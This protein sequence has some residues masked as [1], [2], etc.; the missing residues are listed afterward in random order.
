[1]PQPRGE[2]SSDEEALN[3]WPSD[4]VFGGG[5]EKPL[6]VPR[7]QGLAEDLVFDEAWM[8]L[9]PSVLRP[10]GVDDPHSGWVVPPREPAPPTFANRYCTRETLNGSW[11]LL[12]RALV[13]APGLTGLLRGPM[14][15]EVTEDSLRVSGDMYYKDPDRSFEWSRERIFDGPLPPVDSLHPPSRA[16]FVP[17]WGH[18]WYPHYPFNQY[19]WYFRSVGASF[20]GGELY[21]P[22]TRHLWN[23]ASEEDGGQEFD[24]VTDTGWMRFPCSRW[25]GETRGYPQ[26]TVTMQGE[27]MIGGQRF[28]VEAVKTSPYYRG[29]VVEVDIMQNRKLPGTPNGR[30]FSGAFREAGLD[31]RMLVSERDVPEDDSLSHPDA[32]MIRASELQELMEQRREIST[33][34]HSWRLWALVGSYLAEDPN[35]LGMMFD[36]VAPPREGVATFTDVELPDD[37]SIDA[38]SRNQRLGDVPLAHLH[39]LIHEIGHG[40]NLKHP[41]EDVHILERGTTFMN[42]AA[43][44]QLLA[45]GFPSNATFG[46][47]GH[48]RT[49]LIHSPDPQVAPGWKELGWGHSSDAPGVPDARS[50]TGLRS[51]VTNADLQLDLELSASTTV[52]E[53]LTGTVRLTNS[54]D[55]PVTVTR[56]LSLCEG[57]LEMKIRGPGG[58]PTTI[59]G[60][61]HRCC[62]ART[63]EL[64]SGEAIEHLV[65]LFYTNRG[66]TFATPGTYEVWATAAPLAGNGD[67]LQSPRRVLTVHPADTP[68]AAAL[69]ELTLDEHVGR[70]FALGEFGKN[71][72]VADK[73]RR[74]STDYI[75]TDTGTA[76]ALVL[77]NSYSR[78]FRDFSGEQV[79]VARPE[80]TE[81]VAAAMDQAMQHESSDR[82]VG[83]AAALAGGLDG[84]TPM[85]DHLRERLAQ[86][87]AD[88]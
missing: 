70:S 13:S 65:Q 41:I 12:V 55:Q 20:V 87:D 72:Q 60:H 14:R 9:P 24:P 57:H 18:N 46:F 49:S 17:Y 61:S 58:K 69:A 77:A 25:R 33:I 34:G 16:G 82:I 30:S 68:R 37:P 5:V 31:V 47:H 7:L 73:L 26:P 88:A 4:L 80:N 51:P 83:I 71:E 19:R 56:S 64:G 6:L 15:I 79:V 3:M 48:N 44:L 62:T 29:C 63:R 52:G 74:L 78:S 39:T 54:G 76:A 23:S 75:E 81:E 11:R 2:L 38:S 40:L 42:P 59:R 28:E 8:F 85:L 22:F 27:A 1:M 35:A 32:F 86:G 36:R 53:F 10:P 84:V 45:G 21:F 50:V 67:Y 43:D 66:H